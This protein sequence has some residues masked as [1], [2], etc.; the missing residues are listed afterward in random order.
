[1]RY[2]DFWPSDLDLVGWP[3]L[4]KICPRLWLLNQRGYSFLL[5]TYGCRRRAMLSSL[6][7]LVKH[8]FLSLLPT[9]LISTTLVVPC[10]SVL[11]EMER[12]RQ[13]KVAELI[14]H[15]PPYPKGINQSALDRDCQYKPGGLFI[16][17]ILT[18][19]HQNLEKTDGPLCCLIAYF[20]ILTEFLNFSDC[21]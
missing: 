3:T 17:E 6:T 14:K 2:H 15:T 18:L 21:K 8:S 19:G 13:E 7:T 11:L 16:W 20:S 10:V 5:F 9:P 12:V 4:K 1:M